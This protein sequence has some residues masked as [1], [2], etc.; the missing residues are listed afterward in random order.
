MFKNYDSEMTIANE[1]PNVPPL[2]FKKNLN[3]HDD[4]KKKRETKG[5][6]IMNID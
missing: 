2:S 5:G 4:L 3:N 6:E 1:F